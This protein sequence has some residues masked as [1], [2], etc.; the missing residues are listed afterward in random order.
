LGEPSQGNDDHRWQWRQTLTHY[1]AAIRD[2]P[3]D[4]VDTAAVLRVLKPCRLTFPERG[5]I[6]TVLDAAR[7]LVHIDDNRANPAR[8]RGHLDKLLPKG[9]ANARPP[10]ADVSTFMAKRK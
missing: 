6:E 3:V 7:A 8:W 1:C 9:Q 4:A 10:Y 2:T 5:G